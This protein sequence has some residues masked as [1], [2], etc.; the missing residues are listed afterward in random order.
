MRLQKILRIATKTWHSSQINKY[1]K[2]KRWFWVIEDNIQNIWELLTTTTKTN[3]P[4]RTWAHHPWWCSAWESTCQWRGTQVRALVWEDP[5][6]HEAARPGCHNSWACMPWSPRAVTMEAWAPRACTLQQ[7][8]PPQWE[9]RAPL[10]ER[11]PCS[12]QLGDS[13]RTATKT[14][15]PK[16]NLKK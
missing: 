12:P 2:K 4:I 5:S 10:L 7:E 11:S 13:L 9:A 16:I 1:L 6:C 8:K 14:A 15:Q 3:N